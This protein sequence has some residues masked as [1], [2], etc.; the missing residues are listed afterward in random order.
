MLVARI[1]FWGV[2]AVVATQGTQRLPRVV[3]TLLWTANLAARV[4]IQARGVL[5]PFHV[6]GREVVLAELGIPEGYVWG[7][8][9]RGLVGYESIPVPLTTS[10]GVG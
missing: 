6:P 2:F 7:F 9:V 5:V 10:F 4:A 3:P 8:V 1:V